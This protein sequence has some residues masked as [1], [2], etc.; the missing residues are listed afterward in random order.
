MREVVAEVSPDYLQSFD[1]VFN[2]NELTWLLMSLLG[3]LPFYISREIPRYIDCV[4]EMVSGF[5]TTGSSILNDVEA[6][7]RGMLFWRSFSH[8]VGGMGV[9]VFLMAVVPL[10]KENEGY[11][12]HILRAESPGPIVGKL[13]P[14]MKQTASILYILYIALS[15]IDYV[16]LRIAGMPWFDAMCI[17]FGT[18]GTGGFG[19]LNSSMASYSH[20]AQTVTTVFMFLFGANFSVY[21]LPNKWVNNFL[22]I[23]S[24]C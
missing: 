6:M 1:S 11:T 15:I 13:V 8:W 3:C 16:C 17:M 9:L 20:A 2:S 5:T 23:F 21:Y 4:F 7:S 19:V 12:L 14:R 24:G 10:A 18:A 22:C